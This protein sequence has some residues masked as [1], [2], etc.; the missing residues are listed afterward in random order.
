MKTIEDISAQLAATMV[1]ALEQGIADPDGWQAPWHGA[2]FWGAVNA[3]THKHYTGG[4]AFSLGLYEWAF[5]G[6]RGPWATYRQW[7]SIGGQVR[8]GEKGFVIAV[9]RPCKRTNDDGTVDEWVMF[10]TATVFHSNQ[11]DGWERPAQAEPTGEDCADADALI[12]RVSAE[13]DVRWTDEPRAFYSPSSDYVSLPARGMYADAAHYYST[14]FHEFGHMTGHASRLD[15]AQS[16]VFG[17]KEYAKEELVAEFTAAIL[18][19]GFSIATGLADH[20]RD[21]LA[22][23]VSAL[24]DDP[25]ILW[26]ASGQ[27]AKAAKWLVACGVKGEVTGAA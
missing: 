13:V 10:R 24:H 4:N 1:A 14:C 19:A 2:E 16:N 11:Q 9:P 17:S 8:K 7:Q 5:D 15:R 20:N 18:G 12:D 3:S 25:K 27:A 22:N 26:D 6:V 21:Y 23:W